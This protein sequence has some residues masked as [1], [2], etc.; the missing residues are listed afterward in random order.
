MKLSQLAQITSLSLL[1]CTCKGKETSTIIEQQQTSPM[2]HQQEVSLESYSPEIG[3]F[4]EH[5]KDVFTNQKIPKNG[6]LRII[7][8][9][10]IAEGCTNLAVEDSDNAA[11]ARHCLERVISIAESDLVSPYTN[12]NKTRNFGNHGIYLSHFNVVL[13]SWKKATGDDTYVKLNERISRHLAKKTVEDPYKTMRSYSHLI[14][15]WP[16]DQTVTLYSLWLYDQNYGTD[17]SKEPIAQWLDYMHEHGTDE[18]T[19][20]PLSEVT[21]KYRYSKYPRGCALSWSV[22]YMAHFAPEE[23]EELWG[24]YKEHFKVN[25]GI[26]AAFREY[27]LGVEQK[28]DEDSG[29]IIN[30]IG[31]AATGLAVGASA[32]I[33][34]TITYSQLKIVENLGMLAAISGASK[35]LTAAAHSLHAQAIM[36]NSETYVMWE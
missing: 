15:R 8:L 28:A 4:L 14:G 31:I 32:A 5:P 17:L 35:E 21:G 22:R 13:G 1:L 20:L 9:S 3:Y 23:A 26:G 30:G 11:I 19:S 16:A 12:V 36:F 27:P 7:I 34:D 10:N 29:P 24:N 33:G 2:V 25:F 6:G 18:K